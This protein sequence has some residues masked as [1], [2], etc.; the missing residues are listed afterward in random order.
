[1]STDWPPLACVDLSS[2]ACT[3][4]DSACSRGRKRERSNEA[5]IFS[6]EK[7]LS[8]EFNLE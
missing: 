6:L 1:M 2:C 4:L 5:I 7:V 8:V 3:E